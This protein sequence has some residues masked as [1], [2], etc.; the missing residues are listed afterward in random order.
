M[1]Y[2]ITLN[3]MVPQSRFFFLDCL[4]Q[5]TIYFEVIKISIWDTNIILNHGLLEDYIFQ[6]LLIAQMKKWQI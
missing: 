4:P 6:D 2:A 1:C 3:L 5:N